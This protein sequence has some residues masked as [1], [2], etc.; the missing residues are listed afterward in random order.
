MVVWTKKECL[1]CS[2]FEWGNKNGFELSETGLKLFHNS[3][4]T[5]TTTKHLKVPNNSAI[6]N[7][8]TVIKNDTD[9]K[10]GEGATENM[11]TVDITCNAWQTGQ[12]T[13]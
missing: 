10:R 6:T 4:R 8:K 9:G 13:F 12:N 2:L 3:T 1:C 7:S 5:A 11:V